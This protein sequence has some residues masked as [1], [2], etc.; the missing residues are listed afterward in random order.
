MEPMKQLPYVFDD[1][2]HE[3]VNYEGNM[4]IYEDDSID[5][6]KYYRGFKYTR[7][8]RQYIES[9]KNQMQMYIRMM[10]G[11]SKLVLFDKKR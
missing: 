11:V 4:F 7:S 8:E 2:F 1:I 9:R 10:E 3:Q 6:L 5:Q